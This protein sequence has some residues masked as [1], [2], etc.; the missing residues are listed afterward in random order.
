M[1]RKIERSYRVRK[2]HTKGSEEARGYACRLK[3]AVEDPEEEQ[4][5]ES[6]GE[7]GPILQEGSWGEVS[8][9]RG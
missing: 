2:T 9:W 8:D 5:T 1:N 7:L 3:K 6:R 4:V